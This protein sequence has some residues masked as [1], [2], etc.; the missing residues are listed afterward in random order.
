MFNSVLG[1]G[2]YASPGVYQERRDRERMS[3]TNSMI[4]TDDS[5]QD[6]VDP[7]LNDDEE[8]NVTGVGAPIQIPEFNYG[9][10]H[11]DLIPDI[12]IE[13]MKKYFG[14]EAFISQYSNCQS[15]GELQS[16][17]RDFEDITIQLVQSNSLEDEHI[18]EVSSK[19]QDFTQD[20]VSIGANLNYQNF[21]DTRTQL[22]NLFKQFSERN[23]EDVGSGLNDVVEQDC[24]E[25]KKHR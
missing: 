10:I 17:L 18:S 2:S 22:V 16:L 20:V 14:D 4:R 6:V 19:I 11:G 8:M 21:E 12:H 5:I 9:G 15:L 23:E 1:L 3:K 7:N 24:H 25:G 13:N